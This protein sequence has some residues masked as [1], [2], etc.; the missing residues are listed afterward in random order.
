MILYKNN[1]SNRNIIFFWKYYMDKMKRQILAI[2]ST[3]GHWVQLQ[4]LQSLFDKETVFVCTE[5]KHVGKCHFI[6]IKEASRWNRLALIIQFFQV[7]KIVFKFKPDTVIT[8]GASAG[9]WAM[10]V[11]K[12]L[13]KKTIWIDSIANSRKISLSGRIAKPFCTVFLTQWEDLEE[14]TKGVIFKGNLL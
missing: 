2:S 9:V 12:C 13:N 1:L 10:F 4:R 7:S 6:K 3:G 5:K 8:T 11:G 14:P